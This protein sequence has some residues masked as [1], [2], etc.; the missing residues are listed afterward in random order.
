[1]NAYNQILAKQEAWA[2]NVGFDLIGSQGKHGKKV[3]TTTL[4]DNL[5]KPLHPQTKKE[6]AA[7]DGGEINGTENKPAKMQALH[8]SSAL[9]VNLFDYWRGSADLSIITSL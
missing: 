8:S 7:G 2:H 9:G 5:F 1:M 4:D 6:L 3:Y